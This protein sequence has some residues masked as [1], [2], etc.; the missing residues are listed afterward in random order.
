M[1]T[2]WRLVAVLLLVANLAYFA[3]SQGAFAALGLQPAR[4]G[5]REPHRLEQQVR[6]ELI[7]IKKAP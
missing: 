2:R 1:K 5:E 3:W 4:F 7:E 6:P